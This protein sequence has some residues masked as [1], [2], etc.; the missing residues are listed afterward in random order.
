[1]LTA[2][3]AAVKS[4]SEENIN[5]MFSLMQQCYGR[6]S[7]DKFLSDLQKK[8]DVILLRAQDNSIHGFTTI[9]SINQNIDGKDIKL[10]FSGDTVVSPQYQ[11]R[12]N[13]MAVWLKYA[14]KKAD[15]S[16]EP[17]YW[18]L[19]SNSYKTYKYLAFAKEFY[20][21]HDTVIPEFEK[22]II[23]AFGSR[24]YANAYNGKKGI[25]ERSGYLRKEILSMDDKLL[26]DKNVRFFFEKNPNY[27]FGDE[28]VC[29][30]RV[31]RDNLTP[32]AK[33]I[34]EHT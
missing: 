5:V 14:I 13:L 2:R 19:I 21:R 24:F 9:M 11:G 12:H 25:I 8:E 29:T 7:F 17:V 6:I 23:D 20:P 27:A 3:M 10:L 4:L 31:S 15:S 16:K 34:F 28:L 32:A 26:K 30:A 33:R 18:L 1:M 22:K